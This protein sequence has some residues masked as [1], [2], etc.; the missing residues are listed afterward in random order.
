MYWMVNNCNSRIMFLI[1]RVVGVG[2][3][4]SF[5]I[6][7]SRVSTFLGCPSANLFVD[8][9]VVELS[10][11]RVGQMAKHWH[12]RVTIMRQPQVV[13]TNPLGIFNGKF[14]KSFFVY[15]PCSFCCSAFCR[16]TALHFAAWHNRSDIVDLLLANGAKVSSRIVC[17][18]VCV[19]DVHK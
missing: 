6:H 15:D 2:G 5:S 13:T 4:L 18:Y 11:T 3:C 1:G 8:P 7:R 19:Y 14:H 9:D 16:N 10:A 12:K 17:M